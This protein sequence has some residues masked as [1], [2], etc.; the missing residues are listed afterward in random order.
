MNIFFSKRKRKNKKKSERVFLIVNPVSGKLKVRSLFFDIIDA[1]CSGTDSAPSV[2]LTEYKGHAEQL[3]LN[4]ANDGFDRIICCGGDGTLNETVNGVLKSKKK[5]KIGYIPSGTT[6]DFA[7]CLGISTDVREAASNAINGNDIIMDSGSFC[8]DSFFTYIASFGMF[9]SSSY[10]TPQQSKNVL[11]HMAYVIE[12][13]KDLGQVKATRARVTIGDEVFEDD[14]IFGAVTNTLRIGGVVKL[15]KSLVNLNDGIF[16][17]VLVKAPGSINDFNKILNGIA[18]TNFEN[19][20][21][22]FRKAQS[23]TFELAAGTSWSVDGELMKTPEDGTVKISV[24]KHSITL[25]V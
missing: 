3:A 15:D 25:T 4:A 20:M 13:L 1:V 6:N 8:D 21:F 2:A 16:E 19:D 9:T 23:I 11:G 5:P 24:A 18:T 7:N 22:I 14:Y 17:V 10:A 12:G